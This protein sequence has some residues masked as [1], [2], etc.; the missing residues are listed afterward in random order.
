MIKDGW[1]ISDAGNGL[2]TGATEFENFHE[3][4]FIKAAKITWIM[5]VI[6]ML[7]KHRFYMSSEINCILISISCTMVIIF[8]KINFYQNNDLQISHL[9]YGSNQVYKVYVYIYI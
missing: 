8:Y 3:R 7:K 9:I 2:N 4:W 1:Q 5:I 6:T